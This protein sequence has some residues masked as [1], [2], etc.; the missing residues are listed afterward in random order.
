MKKGWGIILTGLAA[1]TAVALYKGNKKK[2]STL[3]VSQ[4]FEEELT[5][6]TSSEEEPA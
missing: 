6:E 3:L 1:V 5:E 4:D 2:Q